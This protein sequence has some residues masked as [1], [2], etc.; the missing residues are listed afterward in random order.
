MIIDASIM[1]RATRIGTTHLCFRSGKSSKTSTSTSKSSKVKNS[2]DETSK[3][4]SD[5]SRIAKEKQD[6]K[7]LKAK[8]SHAV[9]P[10]STSSSQSRKATAESHASKKERSSTTDKKPSDSRKS[11]ERKK[12]EGR[13]STSKGTHRTSESNHSKSLK[14]NDA[15]AATTNGLSQRPSKM[16]ASQEKPQ[17]SKVIAPKSD[18][19]V[20]EDSAKILPSKNRDKELSTKVW[21]MSSRSPEAIK[22]KIPK[23]FSFLTKAFCVSSRPMG[24]ARKMPLWGSQRSGEVPRDPAEIQPRSAPTPKQTTTLTTSTVTTLISIQTTVASASPTKVRMGASL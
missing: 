19:R 17:K 13:P 9:V 2:A 8:S 5:S 7:K 14:K 10:P 24:I 3:R 16:L 23:G 4:S 18:K 6:I 1:C 12:T 22:R 20:E 15:K 21:L 11:E